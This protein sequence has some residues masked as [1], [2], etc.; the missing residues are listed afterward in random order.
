MS[1][2]TALLLLG[3]LC[4]W[5]Q[6]RARPSAPGPLLCP[7]LAGSSG[8]FSGAP[9]RVFT[10]STSGDLTSGE[11]SIQQAPSAHLWAS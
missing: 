2:G 5:H 11:I 9:M 7:L 1:L 10:T 8:C 3:G 6:S 4:P